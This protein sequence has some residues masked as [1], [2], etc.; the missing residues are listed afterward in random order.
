ME[1]ISRVT[2]PTVDVLK[3]LLS[4]SAPVWGLAIIKVTGRLPGSV[5][6]ILE[7][8][9]RLGWA[10][11]SWDVDTDRSGPRRRLYEL[12]APG[13]AAAVRTCHQFEVRSHTRLV[14][15]TS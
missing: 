8:L 13:A 2:A 11:S 12:T 3:V 4:S 5:Y 14:P 1:P 7:R 15:V 9:E 6:P 10:E